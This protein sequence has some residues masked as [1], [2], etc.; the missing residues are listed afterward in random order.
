[1]GRCWGGWHRVGPA[2]WVRRW[3]AV[4]AA[5]IS[6]FACDSPG[7]AGE[8]GHVVFIVFLGHGQNYLKMKTFHSVPVFSL[9]CIL[10]HLSARHS[11]D[12]DCCP[13]AQAG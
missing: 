12:L 11:P 8:K 10:W 3:E 7:A 5:C 4:G 6:S 13:R 2:C 9:S 1:M